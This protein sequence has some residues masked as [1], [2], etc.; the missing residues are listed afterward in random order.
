[1]SCSPGASGKTP[2]GCSFGDWDFARVSLTWVGPD[3]GTNQKCRPVG[4][5]DTGRLL[6]SPP[7]PQIMLSSL[8]KY[9]P[10]VH[11]VRVGGAHRMVTNCSFPET[12]FIAVTAYQNEEVSACVPSSPGSGQR[13]RVSFSA[14]SQLGG[15]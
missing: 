15:G 6:P 4:H 5:Q 3:P 7:T 1:M 9:E 2:R 12:Q 8:H 11:I 10:Q 14:T 13:V